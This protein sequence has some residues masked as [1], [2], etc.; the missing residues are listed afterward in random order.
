MSEGA[1]ALPP[2]LALQLGERGHEPGNRQ[3]LEARNGPRFTTGKQIGSLVL[4]PE[5]T[6]CH[7]L[8]DNGFVLVKLLTSR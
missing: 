8:Q 7:Q 6:A 2:T 1:D 3:P 4:P 5:G